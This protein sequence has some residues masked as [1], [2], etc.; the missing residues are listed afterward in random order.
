[1]K[2]FRLAVLAICLL[3]GL[4]PA[5]MAQPAPGSFTVALLWPVGAKSDWSSTF[6]EALRAL[7]Y[8]QGRNLA[9]IERTAKAS[10]AELPQLAAELVAMKPNVLAAMST[11]PS[12]ALKRATATIPIVMIAI[13]DP[14][15]SHLVDS[16]AHPGGN[17]TGTANSAETWVAK[18]MEGIA[19]TLPG[20]RCVLTLRNPENQSI[21]MLSGM[22]E[23]LAAK[24]GFKLKAIDVAS[25]DQLDRALATPPDDDCKTAMFLPLDTLFTAR[26]T[27]IAEY[28][29]RNHVALFAPFKGDAEAGALMSF[30]VDINDQWRLSASYVDKILKGAKPEDLPVQQPTQF[31]IVVNLETARA[32]GVTIPQS[33]LTAADEV[34]E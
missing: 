13:G 19:E 17:V 34:I 11:P 15:G 12:L 27:E 14:I 26:R 31:E 10:N 28:A 5:A 2:R 1:M 21:M 6:L 25:G 30:G 24:F 4:T 32:L 7:G 8:E 22:V 9:L 16:L 33:I 18:R 3:F 23:G 29:L 20:I